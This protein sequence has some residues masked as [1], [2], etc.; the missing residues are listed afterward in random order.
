V[1]FPQ[2]PLDVHTELQIGGAWTDV[3]AAPYL[4]DKIAV[5]GGRQDEGSHVDPASCAMT[6]NNRSGTYSPATPHRP[7]TGRSAGTL[8]SGCRWRRAVA[9]SRQ[10]TRL[11]PT[12]G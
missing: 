10:R 4:R 3:S 5:T 7:C 8:R 12:C 6:I 1:A 9:F 2:T 11:H